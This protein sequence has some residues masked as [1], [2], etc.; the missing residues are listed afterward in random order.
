MMVFEILLHLLVRN[1]TRT[2]ST[3]LVQ[4]G[5]FRRIHLKSYCRST[6]LT[7]RLGYEGKAK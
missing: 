3:I 4:S 5:V 7:G 6:V 2:V 1:L